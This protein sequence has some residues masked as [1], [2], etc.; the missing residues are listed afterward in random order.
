MKTKN[1]TLTITTALLIFLTAFNASAQTPDTVC[2]GTVG[3]NYYVTNT[4]GS[5]YNWVVTNGTITSGSGTNSITVTW[6][7]TP[8]VDNLSVIETNS[9]G[10]VGD[11]IT[12]PVRRMPLPTTTVSG[13]TALCISD[14]ANVSIALTGT[15]PWSVT[16]T[17]GTTPTTVNNITASPYIFNTGG[18]TSTKTF[19]VSAVTDRLGCSGSS[20]GSAV[21]TVNPKPS[22]SAIFH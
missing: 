7:S 10:C 18:L 17:N 9:N 1:F 21:V 4:T 5:T 2:A 13:T 15:S 20:S 16:Y 22:T 6:S 19:S 12:L 14:S 8:G 3:K 11:T